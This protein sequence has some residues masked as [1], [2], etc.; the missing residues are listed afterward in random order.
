MFLGT[1]MRTLLSQNNFLFLGVRDLILR[2][3]SASGERWNI[4]VSFYR[5]TAYHRACRLRIRTG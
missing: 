3:A 1:V 5:G 4:L 2:C